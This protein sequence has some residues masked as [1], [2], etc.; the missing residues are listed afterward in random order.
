MDY[1]QVLETARVA[2]RRAGEIQRERFG[3]PGRVDRKNPMEIVTEVDVACEEAV[4]AIVRERYPDHDILAEESGAIGAA[5]GVRSP[6]RWIIDPLDG[7]TNFA[8]GFP[9]FASSVAYAHEGR[10]VV[11]A[12]SIP[13]WGEEFWAVRGGGAF[14]ND[15]ALHVSSVTDLERSFLATG[16]P[17]DV[18]EN[19]DNGLSQFKNMVLQTFAVRR[20]GAAVVDLCCVAAGRFDGFWELR[21]HEWDTAAGAL[22]VEEAG[23]LVTTMSG[24]PWDP[25]QPSIL[26]TNEHLHRAMLDVLTA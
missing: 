6:H 23:G 16:F 4:L 26:A 17:Y 9:M 5:L 10:V 21:L 8:R 18:K 12:C 14:C 13:M 22:L 20:P 25:A 7:T 11:G 24:E 19:P 3:D 1:E 15:R 2:A